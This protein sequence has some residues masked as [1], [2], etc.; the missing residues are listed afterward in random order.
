MKIGERIRQLRTEKKLSQEAL[1]GELGISRQAVAK[2]E[3]GD[4]T[5]SAKNLIQLCNLF[6]LSLDELMSGCS[7]EGQQRYR[8]KAAPLLLLV[9]ALFVAILFIILVCQDR[10]LPEHLIGYSDESTKI[11]VAGAPIVLYLILGLIFLGLLAVGLWL[12]I[13]DKNQKRRRP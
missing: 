8:V 1:A 2:W 12:L 13:K 6:H 3:S 5:P 9:S 10:A 7:V 11:F 4:S